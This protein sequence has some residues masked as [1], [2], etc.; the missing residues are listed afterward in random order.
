MESDILGHVLHLKTIAASFEVMTHAT[1]IK[2][3]ETNEHVT[4][5]NMEPRWRCLFSGIFA[6]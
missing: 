3:E 6:E 5:F 4:Y 1:I 2:Y